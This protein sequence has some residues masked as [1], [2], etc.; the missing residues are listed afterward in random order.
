MAAG[1]LP[2]EFCTVDERFCTSSRS[3]G[4][5]ATLTPGVATR[6]ICCRRSSVTDGLT[7][8]T[9]APSMLLCS[10]PKKLTGKENAIARVL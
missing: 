4:T 1:I 7:T 9:V 10:L 6:S 8:A 2:F 5:K 3:S